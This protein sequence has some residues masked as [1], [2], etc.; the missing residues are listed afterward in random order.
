[1]I[2]INVEKKMPKVGGKVVGRESTQF[3][4]WGVRTIDI[5]DDGT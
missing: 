3:N 4:E 5:N 1:L 2:W